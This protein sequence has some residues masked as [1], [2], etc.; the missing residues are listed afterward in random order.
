VVSSEQTL[1][2]P[3]VSAAATDTF[4]SGSLTINGGILQLD[5]TNAG[6]GYN[7]TFTFNNSGLALVGAMVDMNT[8]YGTITKIING[9]R[10]RSG[11]NI[12]NY[13][14][15]GYSQI[16][17]WVGQ[18]SGS[19]TSTFIFSGVGST[20][21]HSIAITGTANTYSGAVVLAATSGTAADN[22]TF[23]LTKKLRSGS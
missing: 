23:A 16:E 17:T 19:G 9:Q 22:S 10:A 5:A 20:S 15:G 8:H 11:N 2:A 7:D 18:L 21:T 12:F 13:S 1:Y 3:I 4:N 14:G 6:G